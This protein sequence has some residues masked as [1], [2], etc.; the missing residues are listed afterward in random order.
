VVRKKRKKVRTLY[1][2]GSRGSTDLI[3]GEKKNIHEK[4]VAGPNAG[5]LTIG[6]QKAHRGTVNRG[7][8]EE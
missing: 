1:R 5:R 4:N 2:S 8:R 6:N 7:G 3:K